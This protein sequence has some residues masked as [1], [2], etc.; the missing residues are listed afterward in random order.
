MFHLILQKRIIVFQIDMLSQGH[1]PVFDSKSQKLF[2]Y[3]SIE[4]C[5][6][7][8]LFLNQF[9]V[10]AQKISVVRKFFRQKFF[11]VYLFTKSWRFIGVTAFHVINILEIHI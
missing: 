7:L 5:A 6:N 2:S 4:V 1:C 3:T 11:D 9:P 8:N 10:V